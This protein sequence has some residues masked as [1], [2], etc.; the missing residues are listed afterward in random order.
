LALA[1][2]PGVVVLVDVDGGHGVGELGAVQQAE[3]RERA[4]QPH[5]GCPGGDVADQRARRDGDLQQR[6]QGDRGD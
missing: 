2:L 6:R 3:H 1:G 5:R 4:Q